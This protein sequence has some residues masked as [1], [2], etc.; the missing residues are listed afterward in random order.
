MR[1]H[2]LS[3]LNHKHQV[4]AD[5]DYDAHRKPDSN[6][7]AFSGFWGRTYPTPLPPCPSH[8]F[9][10]R[11]PCLIHPRP[12]CAT[13]DTP[14]SE[15]RSN[16]HQWLVTPINLLNPRGGTHCTRT[17]SSRK[18]LR[19]PAIRQTDGRSVTLPV[20]ASISNVQT[21]RVPTT[22]FS[23]MSSPHLHGHIMAAH[24]K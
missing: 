11:Q 7:S 23:W 14:P 18:W 15:T 6:G 10:F 17:R 16:P 5:A 8:A 12:T 22:R 20:S 13:R 2:V 4:V 1:F 24:Q 3:L 9:T 19:Q 21:G